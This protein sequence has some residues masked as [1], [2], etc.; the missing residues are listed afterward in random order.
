MGP[1][2]DFS[3][4]KVKK[5]IFSLEILEFAGDIGIIFNDFK[6]H[7]TQQLRLDKNLY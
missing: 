2:Y 5:S 3:Y 6:A 7:F 4:A 1:T